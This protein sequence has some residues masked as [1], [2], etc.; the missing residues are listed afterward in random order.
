MLHMP[1]FAGSGILCQL[2]NNGIRENLPKINPIHFGVG[3]GGGGG[4]LQGCTTLFLAGSQPWIGCEIIRIFA[5]FAVQLYISD[6]QNLNNKYLRQ[7]NGIQTF[8]ALGWED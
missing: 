4:G 1:S 3:R 8:L 2:H 6:N 7:F 5:Y